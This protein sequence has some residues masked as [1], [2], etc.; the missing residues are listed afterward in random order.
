[1][2]VTTIGQDIYSG[3]LAKSNKNEP[4]NFG[5]AEIIGRINR[6]L[7]GLY[8]VAARVNP[9]F[10]AEIDTVVESAGTWARP[11][12]GLSI[13][14]I[15]QDS[16]DAEVVIL[17]HDDQQAEPSKLCVYEFGQVFYAITNAT[18]TPTGD[19]NFWMS[20]RPTDITNLTPDTLDAQWREDFNELLILELAIDLSAKDGRVD[21]VSALITD[22]NG[23]LLQFINFLQHSTSGL[24][25]R[26]GH[27][28][29]IN[30][31]QL[32][33]LVAGGGR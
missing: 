3:A 19:L 21:E 18:G 12:D 15:E 13:V 6:R 28:K 4:G 20:R 32:L 27:R 9:D 22:R 1:M 17:P 31:E 25:R 5:T 7:A 8:Q 26:H 23:W 16:D 24:R 11:E 14:K 10:F 33:P 29:H 30:L 2:A